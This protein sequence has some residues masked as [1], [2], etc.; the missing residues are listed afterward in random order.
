[1]PVYRDRGRG[2]TPARSPDATQCGHVSEHFCRTQ[3]GACDKANLALG[4]W[5]AFQD[6][7]GTPT[8]DKC[9]EWCV[10]STTCNGFN[11]NSLAGRKPK[12]EQTRGCYFVT[13]DSG[14]V[15][16]SNDNKLITFY[17]LRAD[18]PAATYIRQFPTA[19]A[20]PRM[21]RRANALTWMQT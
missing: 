10:D 2:C 5:S 8:V 9:K 3:Y 12:Q 16:V 17:R 14:C 1:M 18:E 4:I 11:Y 19:D 13:E 21:L 6:S 7:R 15:P 20:L